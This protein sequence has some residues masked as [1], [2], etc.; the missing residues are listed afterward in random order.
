MM[1][2]VCTEC[3]KL[4]ANLL[5][6]KERLS[7]FVKKNGRKHDCEV[8]GELHALVDAHLQALNEWEKHAQ[9]H[10]DVCDFVPVVTR[11]RVS[12]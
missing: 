5:V 10:L 2:V 8:G 12:A 1:F 3:S 9:S 11:L 6:A 4:R 7:V